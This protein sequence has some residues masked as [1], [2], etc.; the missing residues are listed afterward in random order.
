MG[1]EKKLKRLSGSVLHHLFVIFVCAVSLLPY[2]LMFIC[3]L[4]D[5]VSIRKGEMLENISFQN[6]VKNFSN[7]ISDD[8]FFISIRNTFIISIVTTVI[9]VLL[10]SMAGYAYVIYQS[11]FMN[12]L[13]IVTFLSNMIPASVTMIPLFLVLKTLGLLDTY[14][15]VILTSLSLPFL[16]YLFRQNT[17]L[18]PVELIKSAQIDGVSE[19]GIFFKI[20]MPNI[21][22]TVV[23]AS[24]ILF[25]NTWNS[26]LYPLIVI[27]TREKTT[28][29]LYINS[30]GSSYTTDYGVFMMALLLSTM[31]ILL[32]FSIAQKEFKRGFNVGV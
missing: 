5:S 7:V 11:K 1:K 15:A 6:M 8:L 25:I 18:F 30:M 28:L 24:I 22:A 12:I 2:G 20:Y 29:G 17:K 31:P 4:N 23:T 14:I 26:F 19:L 16:V 13:F 27:Q 10:A 21:R 32:I 3:S 9:G